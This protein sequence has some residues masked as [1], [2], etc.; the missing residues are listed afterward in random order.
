MRFIV[1]VV[2]LATVSPASADPIRFSG[3]ATGS[4]FTP[5]IDVGDGQAFYPVYQGVT[6]YVDVTIDPIQLTSFYHSLRYSLGQPVTFT[7]TADKVV[8]N[9]T[10]TVPITGSLTFEPFVIQALSNSGPVP[11]TQDTASPVEYFEVT[12][13]P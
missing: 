7:W 3:D 5:W 10:S 12:H 13:E 9:T 1:F 4:S 6:R 2:L 8:P 11:L